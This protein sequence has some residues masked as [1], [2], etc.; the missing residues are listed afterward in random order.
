M[1]IEFFL[2]ALFCAFFTF[3]IVLK[4]KLSKCY[5]KKDHIFVFLQC[6]EI[7]NISKVIGFFINYKWEFTDLRKIIAKTFILQPN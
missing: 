5:I 7:L 4:E 2:K 3:T 1:I 6:K